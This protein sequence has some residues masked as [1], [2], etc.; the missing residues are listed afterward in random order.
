[1]EKAA[2]ANDVLDALGRAQ[3]AA[4]VILVQK[5]NFS[6]KQREDAGITA[7]LSLPLNL[8]EMKDTILRLSSGQSGSATE[9]KKVSPP[10]P[11][12]WKKY[13]LGAAGRLTGSFPLYT[14]SRCF[15]FLNFAVVPLWLAGAYLLNLNVFFHILFAAIPLLAAF[16]SFTLKKNCANITVAPDPCPLSADAKKAVI[17][18][19]ASKRRSPSN[20]RITSV[21]LDCHEAWKRTI[22]RKKGKRKGEQKIYKKEHVILSKKKNLDV[23][24]QDKTKRR[25][26]L[27]L[28]EVLP[29]SGA[30]TDKN[31]ANFFVSGGTVSYV[32]T[33]HLAVAVGWFSFSKEIELP[34][35][36]PEGH[37][38]TNAR[39]DDKETFAAQ[40]K[41]A[42]VVAAMGAASAPTGSGAGCDGC[43]G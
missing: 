30:L 18:L 39:A 21:R 17:V 36:A 12:C 19:D 16:R 43:G 26:T 7:T 20:V 14:G 37:E 29:G 27:N 31:H 28:G 11:R 2:K 34:V 6:A 38:F 40:I 8:D 3:L 42:L 23:R 5:G 32:S 25:I 35:I 13:K 41:T 22:I 4:S 10:C 9:E 24:L 15:A 33:L 1:N